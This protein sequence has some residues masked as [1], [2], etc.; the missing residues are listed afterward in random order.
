MLRSEDA[1]AVAE[2]LRQSPQAVFWPEASVKEIL[3]WKGSLGTAIET[4]GK[5]VGFLIGRQTIEEAEVLNLAVAPGSRRK[6][7]GDALLQAAVKEF[8]ARGVNRVYLEVRE[9][10]EAGIAF[11]EKHG[12]LKVGR[13][14]GYYREPS[15]TAVIMHKKLAD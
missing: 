1:Q 7:A 12:F 3:E 5:V 15:E 4:A 2:I 6:G 9:S 10:N 14:A 8:Q 13:R 11:Y